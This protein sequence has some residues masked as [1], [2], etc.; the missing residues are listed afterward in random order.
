MKH[1]SIFLPFLFLLIISCSGKKSYQL[2]AIEQINNEISSGNFTEASKLI[3][4]RL[5]SDT[6]PE[7][8][9]WNL[10]FELERMDRIRYDFRASDSSVI[11]YI[12]KYY[13]NVTKSEIEHWEKTNALENMIIDGK[14]CYFR[15]A[16][17]NLFRIDSIAAKH[18]VAVEGQAGD[19]LTRFLA[20]HIP[21]LIYEHKNVNGTYFKPVT[22]SVKYTLSVK[23]NEVPDGEIVRVWM[24]YP[25]GDVRSQS[26]I[27]LISTSQPDFLISPDKYLHKSIYMEKKAVKDSAIIFSY[28]L[29]YTC[30]S[31]YFNF[32][33]NNIK[34]YNIED[35]IY[36]KYTS[37]IPPHIVFSNKIKDA[38]AKIVGS[39]TNPYKKIKLIYEWI[40]SNFPW[41]SAREYS[42]IEN[43]PEYV[44][45]N[46]HGD[47]GQVSL[48]LITMA[49]CAGVPAKWQSGWMMHPGNLNLHDWAEIYYE[50]IGWVPVDQS[51]GRVESALGNDK[52]YYF[53]TKGIDAYRMIVNQDISAPLFPAKIYPRSET[54][55]FQRGEVEWKGGNLYFDRWNYD[56]EVKYH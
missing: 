46:R 55:D 53:Y 42:T 48:L 30:Y 3:K 4:I 40:D 52:V 23:P 29:E 13:P 49:R 17:R 41:A 2:P 38:V 37:E 43:I 12:K 19:S 14:K 24:P 39:E 5:M 36:K 22:M 9:R 50:G 51:F 25:R 7:I 35:S 6:L 33:P 15:S 47:C 26:N 8:E 10:N 44:L 56:M 54:V 16:A 45:A 32:D 1:K 20:R 11:N 31:Q 21:Q 34:P 27:R 18:F 28:N